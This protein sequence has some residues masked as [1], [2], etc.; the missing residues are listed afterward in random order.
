[1]FVVS[2]HVANVLL[3]NV[4]YNSGYFESDH[5]KTLVNKFILKRSLCSVAMAELG[6][7]SQQLV[8][9]K[10]QFIA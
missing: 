2:I 5:I 6:Q 10:L 8:H 3:V 4:S 9:S 1:M 7:V